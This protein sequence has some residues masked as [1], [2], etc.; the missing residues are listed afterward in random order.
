MSEDNR[1]LISDSSAS[2]ADHISQVLGVLDWR[3]PE[4]SKYEALTTYAVR[5]KECGE[6]VVQ[7]VSGDHPRQLTLN[8]LVVYL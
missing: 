3:T 8:G 7:A 2:K 4:Y 6:A 1:A 5:G